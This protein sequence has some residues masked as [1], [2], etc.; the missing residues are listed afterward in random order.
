VDDDTLTLHAIAAGDARAFGRWIAGAE[1]PLRLSLRSFASRLDVEATVQDTLLRAWQAAPR[2]VP[3]GKPECLLR[4]AL[5][6]ARNLAIDE[7]RR[8]RTIPLPD[9]ASDAVADPA[10]HEVDPLLRRTIQKCHERLAAKPAQA[11]DARLQAAGSTPDATL[12]A[13]L[14]MRLNTFLQNVTRA[15]RLLAECLRAHGVEESAT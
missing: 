15:R 9:D 5:R 8:A 1:R 11:L 10:A 4:F 12:A 6:T 2:I 14:G 13:Q 3:D 7:V